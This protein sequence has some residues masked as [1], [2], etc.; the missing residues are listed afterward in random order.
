VWYL[1][2]MTESQWPD[3]T[4][5]SFFRSF[6]LVSYSKYFESILTPLD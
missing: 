4:A 2:V 5:L 6:I 3:E 1:R